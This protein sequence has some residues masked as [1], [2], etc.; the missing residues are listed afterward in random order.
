MPNF[1]ENKIV[2]SAIR[3]STENYKNIFDN[4]EDLNNAKDTESGPVTLVAS[5][6][7]LWDDLE[8]EREGDTICSQSQVCALHRSGISPKYM[9]VL[10]LGIATRDQLDFPWDQEN[11]IPV[12]ATHIH[13]DTLSFL[14]RG[15]AYRELNQLIYF[16][17]TV[18]PNMYPFLKG[19][20][21]AGGCS[22]NLNYSLAHLLGYDSVYLAGYD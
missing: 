20:L 7:S 21:L 11:V 4:F 17:R 10:D 13:P 18:L 1:D 6:P 9:S 8:V 16:N 12:V 22:G 5:G 14:E 19:T 2:Y 15:Y 3:H